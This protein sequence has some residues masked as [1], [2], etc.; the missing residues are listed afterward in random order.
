MRS[1][2]NSRS[3]YPP[4]FFT[5]PLLEDSVR[6]VLLNEKRVSEWEKVNQ[7]LIKN[8]YITNTEARNVTGIVQ[9]DR[10]TNIEKLG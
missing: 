2:M 7:Y 10:I 3:L 5:Y 1:E 6:V 9:R 8:K 4:I